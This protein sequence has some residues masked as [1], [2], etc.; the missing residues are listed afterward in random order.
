M[1]A[2]ERSSGHPA[3]G[4]SQ[5]APAPGRWARNGWGPPALGGPTRCPGSSPV[6]PGAQARAGQGAVHPASPLGRSPG[7]G[8]DL[9][10][11]PHGLLPPRRD[12]GPATLPR[13]SR[14]LVRPRLA[15]G[16]TGGQRGQ[17]PERINP[18][19]GKPRVDA[20]IQNPSGTQPGPRIAR[21]EQGQGVAGTAREITLVDY[22]YAS[23]G[24]ASDN[25]STGK[26][27]EALGSNTERSY[28]NPSP[29]RRLPHVRQRLRVQRGHP[30]GIQ[31]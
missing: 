5:G 28:Y 18:G 27:A 11:G 7:A 8:R 19:P 15:P 10:R 3:L 9:T 4:R 26:S 31:G 25:A 2:Q 17:G 29:M 13:V 16:S 21:T 1:G 24:H 14:L 12:P 6:R 20:R 23:T 30:S 22:D